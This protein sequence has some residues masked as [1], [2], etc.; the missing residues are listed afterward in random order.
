MAFTITL[1]FLALLPI[2]QKKESTA[3]LK[4]TID[5]LANFSKQHGFLMVNSQPILLTRISP[6]DG[7]VIKVEHWYLSGP[8]SGNQIK[9][10]ASTINWRTS[11]LTT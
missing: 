5:W 9:N 10:R 1:V 4:E 3:P 8:R 7:C 2:L 6:V 11:I